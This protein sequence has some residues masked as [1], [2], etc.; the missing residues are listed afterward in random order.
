MTLPI[1]NSVWIG[2][3]LGPINSAC[4]RSF[5]ERGHTTVLHV[6]EPPVDAPEGIKLVD[7]SQILPGDRIYRYGGTG[8]P[9]IHS[10]LM[11][12]EILRKGLGLYVDTDVYCLKPIME[13]DYVYGWESNY[14]I[15]NAVLK[16][17]VDSK[18]LDNLASI[19]TRTA[20]IP[21]W[22][23]IRRQT[24]YRARALVGAPVGIESMPWGF[25]GPRA[26]T[27]YLRQ[28]GLAQYAAPIDVYYPVH[29]DQATLL[30]DSDMRVA[31]LITPRTRLLHLSN[32]KLRHMNLS[33]IPKNS[34][35][36]ELINT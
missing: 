8:S 33:E 26:L 20:F 11:R 9:A 1:V 27:Y 32:E 6:Y 29:Y 25:T 16:L 19:R 2:P 7:A 24:Y 35:L 21:P 17:P 36:G 4:L 3:R 12:Y 10:D 18:T 14:L 23:S 30:L 22:A 5:V 28:E 13:A 15:N 34:P 31:D